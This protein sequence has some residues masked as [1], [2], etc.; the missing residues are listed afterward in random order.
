MPFV[1]KFE[2]SKSFCRRFSFFFKINILMILL[3]RDIIHSP[4]REDYPAIYFFD[5]GAACKVFP[6]WLKKN[7]LSLFFIISHCF[8]VRVS[9]QLAFRVRR[10]AT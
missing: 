10:A 8:M 9:N 2:F 4:C 6:H 3:N 5:V 7:N 1:Y